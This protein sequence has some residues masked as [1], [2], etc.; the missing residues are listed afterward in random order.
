VTENTA[1]AMPENA[2]GLWP[3]VGF[4]WR[5]ARLA[6]PAAG[7]FLG[8]TGARVASASDLLWLGIATHF[9]RAQDLARLREALEGAPA[10][11]DAV[12]AT[13]CAAAAIGGG[14]G[15]PGGG[16]APGGPGPLQRAAPA[17]ER[18]FAPLLACGGRGNVGASGAAA[19]QEAISRLKEARGVL[20]V[21]RGGP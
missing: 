15:A 2:I 10:D 3:D 21:G 1:F 13:Q 19:L 4:A 5:A 12:V 14:G 8:L 9:C 20:G 11:A 18:C 6:S 17:L 16:A 7:L